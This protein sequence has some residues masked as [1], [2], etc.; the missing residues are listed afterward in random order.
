MSEVPADLEYKRIRSLA[1][2][3]LAAF[4][5]RFLWIYVVQH[6][7]EAIRSDM[8]GYLYRGASLHPDGNS[9]SGAAL[10]CF[11]FGTHTLYGLEQLV[12]GLRAYQPMAWVQTLLNASIVPCSMALA[13]R[14]GLGWRAGCCVGALISLWP[15]TFVYTSYFSSETPYMASLLGVCWVWLRW[16]Q[17]GKNAWLVGSLGAIAFTI[18]PQIIIT[19]GMGLCWVFLFPRNAWS[20]M[21][22]RTIPLLVMPLLMM[23]TFSVT[24]H[25]AMTGSFG[26]ISTNSQVGRFFADTNYMRIA[27]IPAD[28]AH[29]GDGAKPNYFHPPARNPANGFRQEFRYIGSKCDDPQLEQER[30]RWLSDKPITY[31][32]SLIQRNI[33]FLFSHNDLWPERNHWEQPAWRQPLVRGTNVFFVVV[34]APLSFLALLSLVRTRNDGLEWLTLHLVTMLLTAALFFAELRYRV[35]YDPVF[36]LMAAIGIRNL[37]DRRNTTP[38]TRPYQLLILVLAGC[39]ALVVLGPWSNLGA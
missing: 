25:K 30:R 35:P 12:F 22:R 20:P 38:T 21:I 34:I 36:I 28:Q 37:I 14:S 31:R 15:M 29:L 8:A 19:L 27:A 24:R 13:W 6:P 10:A 16:L 33:G 23:L 7:D 32:F 9:F 5:L 3:F 4:F 26:L 1:C 2:G 18:R 17:T 11:P 39:V